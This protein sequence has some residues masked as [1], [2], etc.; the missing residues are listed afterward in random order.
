MNRLSAAELEFFAAHLTAFPEFPDAAPTPQMPSS[1]TPLA[2]MGEEMG[3]VSSRKTT[4]WCGM[5]AWTG[6][7]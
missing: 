6:T 3:S 7:S 1:P 2:F 5:S 4:S